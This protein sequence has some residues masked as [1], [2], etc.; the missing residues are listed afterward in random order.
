MSKSPAS[1]TFKRVLAAAFAGVF[2]FSMAAA[3]KKAKQ[4]AEQEGPKR[5]VVDTRSL[6]WPQPPAIARVKFT[7]MYTGEKIDPLLYAKKSKKRDWK[8]VL[9]GGKTEADKMVDLPYQFMCV[10][11]VAT[12]SKGN[13]YAADQSVGA[14]FRITP[15]EK[16]SL[17]IRN[18]K[19]A[20]LGLI[21]GLAVDD[22]DRIFLSD[23]KLRRV[24][25]FDSN[26]HQEAVV[27]S[28]VLAN[29]GGIALD[30][31]NRFLYVA[32]SDKDQVVVF[33]A[34][35]FKLLRTIGTAGKKHTLTGPG[36]FAMPSNI[37]VDSE[38]DVY[39]SDTLNSRVQIFDADGNY[40]SEFGKAGD[41]PGRFARP[42]GIAVDRDRHVW[43][44]DE[45]QSRVQVFDREGRLLIYFGAQGN[46][47]G[48]FSA[49]YGIAID[50]KNRVIVSE[51]FPGRVQVFQYVTDAEAAAAKAVGVAG[52]KPGN[53][54][55]GKDQ[56]GKP[57]ASQ[58]APADKKSAPAQAK[59]SS[60][61]S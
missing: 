56:A 46:Y 14:V 19:E 30:R 48:M 54:A 10:Y 34:D 49:A 33:D 28:G 17:A 52:G 9:A 12:D 61:V 31:E 21:N 60:T 26:Y 57:P 39:V 16:V 29:P 11:G 25:V 3:D 44:V 27:G 4:A 22:N 58:A 36:E 51:Q 7:A 2:C 41:G 55:P 20:S 32:D 35:T 38:G 42:K 5:I 6:V 23:S 43:V 1:P 13:I 47:P 40:I 53:P 8:D 24:L 18:G 50:A 45:L 37:A 59:G 15:E